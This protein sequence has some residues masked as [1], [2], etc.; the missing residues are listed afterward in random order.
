MSSS[1]KWALIEVGKDGQRRSQIVSTK[2]SALKTKGIV[3]QSAA[4][5]GIRCDLRG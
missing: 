1:G 5:G 2:V 3:A 4:S